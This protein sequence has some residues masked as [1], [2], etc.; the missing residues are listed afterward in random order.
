MIPP[1]GREA[2]SSLEPDIQRA[3]QQSEIQLRSALDSASMVLWVLDR[4]GVFTYSHG[5]ILETL[6]LR[7]AEVVGRS[8]FEMY[9]DYPEVIDDARRA[10]AGEEFTAIREVAGITFE[11]RYSTLR[12]ERG[13]P[14]GVIGI[15]VDVTE[16]RRVEADRERALSLLRASLES[17][18]DG[19]LVV[20]ST[21]AIVTYNNKFAEMWGIPA[22]VMESGDDTRAIQHVL[23]QLQDP[24]SFIDRVKELYANPE[25][26]SFD[27]VRFRNGRVFE[28]YSQP[29]RVGDAVVGR[30]WSF[31]DVTERRR[32]EEDLRRREEQLRH[33]QR[34]ARLGSWRWDVGSTTVEWSD[35]L[36]RIYGRDPATYTPTYEGYLDAVHPDDRE[37]VRAILDD[38]LGGG[39]NFEFIERIIRPDGEVRVL[40]SLGEVV[41]DELGAPLRLI[42]ACQDITEQE[43]AREAL[44]HAEASYRA[45][46]DLANDAIFVHDI[47]T[48]HIV[49]ANPAACDLGQTSLEEL[50][51]L[52]IP[53]DQP[54]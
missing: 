20:D 42:G 23:A 50:K 10:L 17:T 36:Y 37:R 34:L 35:E 46:F 21:G 31:R 14:A 2:A 52:G 25:A 47:E 43:Q 33:T 45:I 19:I 27:V 11:I 24:D 53:R 39:T 41:H 28:R 22:E 6:G 1:P 38:A 44:R 18:A 32:T 16:R 12:D 13:K 40:R 30:V 54:R 4:D 29:Q 9:A 15:A 5:K 26:Q 48:G 8:V 51:E 49:D 3:L 7:A